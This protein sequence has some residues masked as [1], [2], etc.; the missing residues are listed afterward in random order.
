MAVSLEIFM[1]KKFEKFDLINDNEFYRNKKYDTFKMM[2][3]YRYNLSDDKW[4]E[5]YF[6]KA[7]F[8]NPYLEKYISRIETKQKHANEFFLEL[9]LEDKIDFYKN[10]SY[11]WDLPDKKPGK[12]RADLNENDHIKSILEH[13]SLITLSSILYRKPVYYRGANLFDVEYSN[14]G[15]YYYSS[16]FPDTIM[17]FVP[18]KARLLRKIEKFSLA[19]FLDFS[20]DCID[21]IQQEENFGYDFK[22][23]LSEL[24]DICRNTIY[25]VEAF[26]KSNEKLFDIF[27][28]NN[29]PKEYKD[30]R[31][32]DK[33]SDN[34]IE[35][36]CFDERAVA[37]LYKEFFW[38]NDVLSCTSTVCCL[39]DYVNY[40]KKSLQDK[41]FSIPGG[42]N[43]N[44][45]PKDTL[46]I[47][48]IN[49]AGIKKELEWQVD[50]LFKKLEVC[51]GPQ[52]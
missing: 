41:G 27:F 20:C 34:Y 52:K 45:D 10:K 4:F 24:L 21:H 30:F 15:N 9:I 16:K 32:F 23:E 8:P 33:I 31:K 51:R 42:Y 22:K 12:W 18:E 26:L 2:G 47:D 3:G 1:N 7:R 50:H 17:G 25:I 46:L 38:Q 13:K 39:I 29:Y 36:L 35:S 49:Y 19:T 48:R 6:P 5:D 28:M 14:E 44:R 37:K 11:E 40:F 43:S